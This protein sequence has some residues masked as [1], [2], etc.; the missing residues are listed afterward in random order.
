MN[1][2]TW[3]VFEGIDGSG[4]TTQAKL[5]NEYLLSRGV[6]S[7]YKHVFD[8]AAGKLLREMFINNTFSNT[9][10]I[11]ILCAARQAFLDETAAA[12]DC[13]VMIIDRF[14][15]SILAMQGR[16][17]EDVA[18]IRHLQNSICGGTGQSAV[19]YMN[20][21]PEDCKSRLKSRGISDRIEETGVEFHRAVSERYLAFLRDE[22]NVYQFDGNGDIERIHGTI[23]DRT[24]PLLGMQRAEVSQ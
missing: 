2:R 21:S 15:L 3:I 9:V 1:Q 8:T 19:F 4:K 12:E 20:T 5:L 13:D 14:F 18:L 24:L 10:E 7:R 16:D 22:E 23:V 6:K 11:L 17:D